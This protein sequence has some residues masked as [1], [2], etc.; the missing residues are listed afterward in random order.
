MFNKC[1]RLDY[2]CLDECNKPAIIV[3][4]ILWKLAGKTKPA[5][6]N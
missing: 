5:A 6:K 3:V 2:E 1:E 4:F